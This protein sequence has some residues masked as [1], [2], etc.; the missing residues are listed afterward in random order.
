M[1]NYI[2]V[3]SYVVSIFFAIVVFYEM[4][5]HNMARSVNIMIDM[6][7]NEVYMLNHEIYTM[8]MN[9]AEKT[10]Q[11]NT[12]QTDLRRQRYETARINT[13]RLTLQRNFDNLQQQF[14][15]LQHWYWEISGNNLMRWMG[16]YDMDAPLITHANTDPAK[17]DV[18]LRH[19]N[20]M[21]I[22]DLDAYLDTL[23]NGH[24][25]IYP[26]VDFETYGW[27][28]WTWVDWMLVAFRDVSAREYYRMEVR[29][30][31]DWPYYPGWGRLGMGHL[32]VWVLAQETPESEPFLRGYNLSLTPSG[33]RN[34]NEWRIY[35]HH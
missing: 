11:N 2:T 28:G 16:L 13:S 29:F 10:E 34:W 4:G 14:D 5:R 15:Y 31:P 22:G 1:R 21:H 12:L 33:G 6:H 25:W 18:I 24:D 35:D 8:S 23:H 32:P 27:S 30:V 7:Q 17:I 20:A 19:F 9:I 3:I 26:G